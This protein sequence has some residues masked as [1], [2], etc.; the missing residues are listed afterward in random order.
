MTEEEQRELIALQA[1]ALYLKKSYTDLRKQYINQ[2]VAIKNRDVIA[3]HKDIS[4]VLQKI[5]RKKVDPATV[6]IEFLHPR[7][8][9]LI[10]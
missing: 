1:D 2:Y 5:R 4:M 7:E 8:M 6:L 10:L 9:I 3:H